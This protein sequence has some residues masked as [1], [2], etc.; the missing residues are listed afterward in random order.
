[1]IKFDDIRLLEISLIPSFCDTKTAEK[2][3]SAL[4]SILTTVIIG[5][6]PIIHLFVLQRVTNLDSRVEHGNDTF[7]SDLRM[8][9][10]ALCNSDDVF[11]KFVQNITNLA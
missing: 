6:D 11:A 5:L 10:N 2:F 8:T 4:W 3:L 9:G 7:F 1:M